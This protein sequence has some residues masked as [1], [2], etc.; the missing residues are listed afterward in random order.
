MFSSGLP[1]QFWGDA[2]QHA[3][4][5]LNAVQAAHNFKRISPMEVLT[6]KKL[7]IADV[8]VFGIPCTVLPRKEIM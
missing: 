6:G 4:N 3:T 2:V 7:S 1:L 5:I 8:V